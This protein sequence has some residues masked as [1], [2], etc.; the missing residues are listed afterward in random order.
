M[1]DA[2]AALLAEPGGDWT[3]DPIAIEEPRGDEILVRIVA[4]GLCH[5]DLA[6]R[7]RHLP[8]PF[9]C[10]LGHEGSGIVERVGDQVTE[11][12]PGDHVVLTCHHCG[13][14]PNC[15]QGK[16]TYCHHFMQLNFS[17]R[18]ADGT[19]PVHA[20]GAPVA[21]AF[22]GQSSFAT[23]ALAHQRN[24]VK[25]AK[26]IDLRLLGPLGCGIQ[27]GAGTVMNVLR[28]EPGSAIAVFGSGAVGLSAVMAARVAGCTRIIAVDVH[29]SRLD[30]ALELGA[31]H[32]VHCAERPAL[33]QIRALG[34][35]VHYAIDTTGI[36]SVVAEA[37]ESLY[38]LG[39]CIMVG[40]GAPDAELR[41][42]INSLFLGKTLAGAIEGN[43]VP[44]VFIP[45]LI[46]LWRQGRFP[47]E[48][49]LQFYPLAQI[50]EAAS[51]S[52]A[53]TTLKPVLLL[54][55]QDG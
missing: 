20:H 17:G 29:Q 24:A 44:K 23:Y 46:E 22:F 11:F 54:E 30:L 43:S 40:V 6:V 45:R 4:C 18:R 13:S 28:A 27:T 53:G 38:P 1:I 34:G 48:K 35:G 21:G 7:D 12:E 37:V 8:T 42:P 15:L 31:T 51:D 16:P 39:T 33:D 36:P 10:V 52:K 2:V 25:V 55:E 26:D 19:S 3:I 5:T 14:C 41:L 49:L 9:P 32:A 50:N 47:F